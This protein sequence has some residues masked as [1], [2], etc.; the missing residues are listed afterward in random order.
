MAAGGYPGDLNMDIEDSKQTEKQRFF[1][2]ALSDFT[3]D[4]ASGGAVRH[5][6]ERGYSTDQIMRE[7]SYPT[8][9]SRVEKMVYRHMTDTGILMEEL[10]APEETMELI[11]RKKAPPEK[12]SRFL[13]KLLEQNGEENSYVQCPYGTWRKDRERRLQEAF[14]CLTAREREYLMGIPWPMKNVYHRLNDRMWEIAV[15]LACASDTEMKFYFLKSRQ[16]VQYN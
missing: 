10:P 9:R 4:V 6:V 1:Q 11:S 7:L 14:A 3:Y 13:G 5:L 15:W 8:A 2:E 12:V 16:I